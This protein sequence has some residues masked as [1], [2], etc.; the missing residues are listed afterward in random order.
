MSTWRL[1]AGGGVTSDRRDAERRAVRRW[2]LVFGLVTLAVLTLPLYLG[3]ADANRWMAGDRHVV[4]LVPCGVFT[5]AVA[6]LLAVVIRRGSDPF[7]WYGGD[8]GPTRRTVHRALRTGQ[9]PDERVDALAR[10]AAGRTVRN[11]KWLPRLIGVLFAL[12][13]LTLISRIG[14]RGPAG[15]TWLSVMISAVYAVA[16]VGMAIEHRRARRYLRRATRDA[17]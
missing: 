6:I 14:E 9:A 11:S 17:T 2:W 7:P 8:E 5:L 10:E 12:Q 13:I 1:N 15:R 3:L 4:L 16:L